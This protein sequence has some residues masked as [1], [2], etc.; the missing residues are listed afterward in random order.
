M[1]RPIL[2]LGSVFALALATGSAS[3]ADGVVEINQ[4]CAN[5]GCFCGDDPFLPVTI[6]GCAGR[7]YRLTSDLLI[8]NPVV[9]GILVTVQDISVDLGGF[10]IRGFNVCNGT[11]GGCAYNGTGSGIQVANGSEGAPDRLRISNGSVVGVGGAG[12]NL[13]GGDGH[14]VRD[15]RVA[16]NGA[17]GLRVDGTAALI[18][19]ATSLRNG[20]AGILAGRSA[21]VVDCSAFDNGD[22]GVRAGLA[23]TVASSAFYSNADAGIVVKEG[24][25]VRD[26][27]ARDNARD[28]IFFDFFFPTGTEGGLVQGC[29]VSGNTQAG[30]DARSRVLVIENSIA[31][32]A[33]TGMILFGGAY[34]SNAILGN[35]GAP[36]LSN[37]TTI[38]LGDN[39]CTDAANAV[40]ACP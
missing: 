37:A 13:S 30:I 27:S 31:D 12:I 1:R 33:S 3:A 7:S 18:E 15:V 36:V 14:V 4:D 20:G 28:G 11:P 6:T 32:N 40:V 5:A 25:T 24:S 39:A 19:R 16:H 29:V 22:A 10:A 23:A 8:G 34:R 38:N 2:A 17:E 21:R 9:S 35:G 26:C